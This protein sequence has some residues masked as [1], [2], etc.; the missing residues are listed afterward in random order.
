MYCTF[1]E[2]GNITQAF[3]VPQAFPTTF[4]ALTDT[5]LRAFLTA[6]GVILDPI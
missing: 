5:N 2:T 4:V 1:D 3:N 6:R